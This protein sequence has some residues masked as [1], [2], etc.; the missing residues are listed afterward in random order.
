MLNFFDFLLII[1]TLG[2]LFY[3][4]WRRVRLW[5]IG[6]PLA[7]HDE[8][9]ERLISLFRFGIAQTRILKESYP[10]LMHLLIFWGFLLPFLVALLVAIGL[11]PGLPKA[12]SYL[13]SLLLDLCGLAAIVGVILA[14]YRRYVQRPDRLDNLAQDSIGLILILA[15]IL[16]GFT[17]ASFRMATTGVGWTIASPVGSTLALAFQLRGDE[18]NL[19]FYGIFRRIHLFCVLGFIA[20][21]PFSKL[22]HLITT[23][24][25]IYFRSKEPKG[26]L[27][28]IAP[29]EFETAET[30]GV[31]QIDQFTWKDLLDLDA[32]TRCGRC[33]DNC[34][35][36][37]SEKPLSPKK[38]IQDLKRCMEEKSPLLLA[39]GSGEDGASGG[40]DGAEETPI[41]GEYVS[42]DELWACTTCRNCLE[43]CPVFIEQMPKIIDLRR[44]LVMMEARFPAEVTTVFKNF[45]VNSNPWGMGLTTRGDWCKELGVKTLAED[46]DIEWLYYVGCSGS[47]DDRSK[48][49][50]TAFVQLL[51]AAGIKFGILGQ[52]EGCC[53]DSARRSGNE[54]LFQIMAQQ[55][56]EVFNAYEVKK[57][58][59]TC[60]HGYNTLKNEYPQLGGSYEVK[61]HSELIA[62]LLAE[63]KL[64]LDAGAEERAIVYHDSCYLGRYNDIYDQPREILSKIPGAS[65]REMERNRE[66]GFCCGA[67]GARMWM[68]E[69]LGNRINEMRTDQALETK[70]S[71]ICTACPFCLTMIEDGIKAKDMETPTP[72]MDIAELIEQLLKRRSEE[73]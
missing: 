71:V 51:Q 33:Q 46:C 67:G 22:F 26:A 37:L 49:V 68:E 45:E 60:P 23:P 27:V 32:C 16:S 28:A 52:E 34:P 41:Q 18:A 29:E 65:I 12:L 21:L 44:Y 40:Q 70:P 9:K 3:G 7:R 20:Y 48:R 64:V 1:I 25:S 63:G 47:F 54:Y 2:F 11:M 42:D 43:H 4:T 69:H 6:K 35:A 19:I 72:T 53:G 59:T 17:V 56:I 58:V 57:I 38:V 30:F 15:I 50:A 5:R 61:H 55:N 13:L 73:K 10:G 36:H 24:L 66:R 39:K 31:S 14:I 8:P 62:E